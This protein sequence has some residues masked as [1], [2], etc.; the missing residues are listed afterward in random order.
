MPAPAYKRDN[1]RYM[2]Q[3]ITGMGAVKAVGARSKLYPQCRRLTLSMLC[4][5]GNTAR[6]RLAQG[7]ANHRP[8]NPNR[9]GKAINSGWKNFVLPCKKRM[10]RNGTYQKRGGIW[11]S[12]R[13]L[14]SKN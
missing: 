11:V 13:G 5:D 10:K 9:G 6:E 14:D 12:V 7:T 4:N 8:F 2:K 3:E 1:A